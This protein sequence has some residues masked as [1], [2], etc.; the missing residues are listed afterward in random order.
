MG[1]RKFFACICV[2]ILFST[3]IFIQAKLLKKRFPFTDINPDC[4]WCETTDARDEMVFL[5]VNSTVAGF[6]A[7]ADPGFVSDIFW[8]KTCYYY[9]AQALTAGSFFYL[10]SLLDIITDLSPRWELPYVFGAVALPNESSGADEALYLLE[11]GLTHNPGVWK[12][13]F[14]KGYILWQYKDAPVQAA[15]AFLQ[16]S[17]IP[18]APIYLSSLSAT[19]ATKAGE[20]ELALRFV[21]T[22]LESITDPRHRKMLLNK[23]EELLN[24]E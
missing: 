20:K 21:A 13:S 18:G 4:P 24:D 1:M 10:F 15:K 9:G 3:T 7:P 16:A 22:A 5:P 17:L 2:F 23:L 12:I 6:S 14:F 8:L 19:L 11:K